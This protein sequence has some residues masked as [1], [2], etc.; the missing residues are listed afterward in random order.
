MSIYVIWKA[1]VRKYKI[2]R[3][4]VCERRM[5]SSAN[6]VSP[7]PAGQL[8]PAA[9]SP[10]KTTIPRWLHRE[11]IQHKD[12]PFHYLKANR[13]TSKTINTARGNAVFHDVNSATSF[14]PIFL[15]LS[16]CTPP[17]TFYLFSLFACFVFLILQTSLVTPVLLSGVI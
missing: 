12:F 4:H 2:I 9:C 14:P 1:V 16:S 5:L 8:T 3:R 15:V 17:P 10:L 13:L 7:V 6:A 11:P